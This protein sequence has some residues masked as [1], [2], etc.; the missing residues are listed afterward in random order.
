M[1]CFIIYHIYHMSGYLIKLL[2]KH[3]DWS[4]FSSDQLLVP[5]SVS[6]VMFVT[7]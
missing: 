1:R 4:V 7:P 6:H 5:T 2:R 3:D